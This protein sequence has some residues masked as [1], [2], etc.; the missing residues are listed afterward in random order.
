MTTPLLPPASSGGSLLPL[1]AVPNTAP[2][3]P[4]R[5]ALFHAGGGGTAAPALVPPPVG[6]LLS[7]AGS[8][9]AVL[10][11][12]VRFL[13]PPPPEPPLPAWQRDVEGWAV[14]RQRLDHVQAMWQYGELSFFA[15][16]WHIEDYRAGLVQRCY[17]CWQGNP[18]GSLQGAEAAIAAAYSQGNQQLCPVC[19]NTTFALPQGSAGV[20]GLRALIVRPAVWTEFDRNQQRQAR[21]VY[22]SAAVNIESTPDFRVR[23][24]DWAFR[25]DGT[26]FYLRVPRR[27]TLRTGFA[28]PWQASA[29]ITYNLMQAGLED[30]QSAA[31]LVPPDRQQVATILGT[32]TRV[33]AS[34]QWAETVNA[35]LIPLETPSPASRGAAQPAAVFPPGSPVP[36]QGL[37][38]TYNGSFW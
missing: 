18:D 31:Y 5:I 34:Y 9:I 16:A 3:A 33:P 13:L 2:A 35:P 24:G 29:G 37:E 15:L 28:S 12:V 14:A 10:P 23:T 19:F 20:P 27:V 17:R 26:R 1:Q 30:G 6:A 32:Y 36:S 11:L 8:G 21:G 7:P 25:A 4:V 22:D 38:D